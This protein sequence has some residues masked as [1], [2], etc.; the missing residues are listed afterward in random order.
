MN[1]HFLYTLN[2]IQSFIYTGDKETAVTSLGI[3]SD[4]SR[5]VLDSSR[6]P[7]ISLFDELALIEN[8]L[9]LEVMRLPKIK[10]QLTIDPQLNLHDTYLPTMII[11]PI[12]EN[13][14]YHGLSNKQGEGLLIIINV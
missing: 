7:E 2:A 3:F 8:Y 6:S 13:A 12:L 9:K 5:G 14:V 11:Q 10:Y 1:P 4:L